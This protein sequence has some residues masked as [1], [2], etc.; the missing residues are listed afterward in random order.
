MRSNFEEEDIELLIEIVDEYLEKKEKATDAWSLLVKIDDTVKRYL[1]R[2]TTNA[3][4][5]RLGEHLN[6]D[7]SANLWTLKTAIEK[8]MERN[9]DKDGNYPAVVKI[10]HNKY[11]GFFTEDEIED[12][13]KRGKEELIRSIAE[14]YGKGGRN[15]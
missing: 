1:F 3:E 13:K 11:I 10:F 12:A 14:T 7:R 2:V 15:A 9:K 4:D 6:L 5:K 8:S